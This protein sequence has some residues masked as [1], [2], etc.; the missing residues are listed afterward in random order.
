MRKT[1]ALRNSGSGEDL[2]SGLLLALAHVEGARQ[3]C[4]P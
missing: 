2:F 1:G 4:C 3:G